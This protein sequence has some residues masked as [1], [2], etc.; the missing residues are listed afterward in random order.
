MQVLEQ[1]II[2]SGEAS[3]ANQSMVDMQQVFYIHFI[4]VNYHISFSLSFFLFL[5]CGI[6]YP[7]LVVWSVAS[8]IIISSF[9]FLLQQTVMRLMTQC[10]EKSFELEVSASF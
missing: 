8:N 4:M 6:I 3:V 10:N 5:F 9:F 2:E 1:R 7:I